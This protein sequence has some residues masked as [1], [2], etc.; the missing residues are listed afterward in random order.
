VHGKIVNPVNNNN[1]YKDKKRNKRSCW[2]DNN[3]REGKKQFYLKKREYKENPS[4]ENRINFLNARSDYCKTKCN[5]KRKYSYKEKTTLSVLS[6]TNP[7]KFWKYVNKYKNKSY[8]SSN[9]I[10][11][12][13]FVDYFKQSSNTAHYSSFNSN[14]FTDNT[15]VPINIEE[16]DCPFTLDEILRTITSLKRNKSSDLYNNVADFFIDS[17]DFIAP[18]LVKIFNYIYDK[19]IYPESWCKGAI[20][21][22]FKKGDR[23]NPA[24][25]RG[26]TLVNI[27][28]KIFSLCLR[29]RINKWCENENVF[30][31]LQ[32]GFRDKRSTTDCIF[33]LHTIIQNVFLQKHKLYCAFIDYEKAFDTVN[34]EALWIKLIESG[35]S[36][37]ML[38]MIQVIYANV[39]SCVK[40][41]NGL[42]FSDFFDVTIGVKQGEPLS[43]L[44]FILFL[45]DIKDCIDIDNLTNNDLELLSVFMLLFADDIVLFTTNPVSLQSQLNAVHQYSIKWGL[46]INV[47]KTKICIFEKQRTHCNFRWNINGE[48]IEIVDSFCYL[49]IKF[50]YTGNMTNI[51]KT[52]NDQALKAYGHLLSIFSRVNVDVKTKLE[53]FDALVTPIIMY[54]SEVWGIYKIAEVD[55]LHYK[56]CKY[57]L[58]VRPS[59]SNAAVLGELGRFPL[60]LQ[61]KQR[62]LK[63]FI[64]IL[65][66]PNSLMYSVMIDQ[67]TLYERN[68][69]NTTR[70]YVWCKSIKTMLDNLGY[71]F[72]YNNLNVNLFSIDSLTQRLKDQYV[73]EWND[74][75]CNQ[76]KL[77]YYKLFKTEF[78]FEKYIVDIVKETHRK[79]LTKFRLSAHCLEIEVG[80]FNNIPRSERK[81]KM[82]NQNVCESEYHFLLCCPKYNEL[83]IKYN[84]RSTWPSINKFVS[85]MSSQNTNALRRLSKFLYDSFRL[86]EESLNILAAS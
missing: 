16:L 41:A 78:K 82:C 17:K 69:I 83:R 81:C 3:C 72:L 62:S 45:N 28:A 75:I 2:F 59:T 18:Y 29:N 32:F 34:H 47:N 42:S 5:A 19:G 15:D 67:F 20:V 1:N 13:E 63:Y 27:I 40:N 37:K 54:G 57:V 23:N 84:I 30:N 85:V 4:N 36:C 10:S 38:K 53:L 71:G 49:G 86:R 46:K 8:S 51:V 33:I 60:A 80:R 61:C 74:L 7:R 56:F 14:D 26:I 70:S 76:P 64:N 39:K 43:P 44:L 79:Q 50:N 77:N 65:N 31:P 22:I 73:Q 55:K 66:K 68:D 58:G 21:P 11:M 24:N 12:Q 9:D 48:C 52:L 35:I 6:K 25:Y